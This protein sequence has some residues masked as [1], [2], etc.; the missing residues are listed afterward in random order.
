MSNGMIFDL[1]VDWTGENP[2][3]YLKDDPSGPWTTLASFFRIFASPKG[4]GTALLLL[5]SP[6]DEFG[7]DS[8]PNV[9]ITDN[10]PLAR[11]LV[12][13][14]AANFAFFRDTPSIP[15]ITYV[16]LDSSKQGG[17][18]LTTYSETVSGGGYDVRLD[19]KG[20]GEPFGMVVPPDSAPTGKHTFLSMFVG[21]DGGTVTLN[22]APLPG[23]PVPRDAF[24]RQ[25]TS[26]FLAF[27]EI[28]MR[29]D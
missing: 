2:G 22:G 14:F 27:S 10:E 17:D 25:I 23:Q 4:Q 11:W 21:T 8:A 12:N 7:T 16:G 28:W 26:A 18:A 13:D 29:H 24:G 9:C 19:W 5:A 1:P 6:N 3:V 20:L 15:A